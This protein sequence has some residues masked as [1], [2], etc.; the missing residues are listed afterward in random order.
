MS[1]RD[2]VYEELERYGI[3]PSRISRLVIKEGSRLLVYLK[4]ERKPVK[5][6][7][8]YLVRLAKLSTLNLPLD[9]ELS[10][11]QLLKRLYGI[12]TV[13]GGMRIPFSKFV[14]QNEK[15]SSRELAEELENLEKKYSVS[16]QCRIYREGLEVAILK[17]LTEMFG[18][19]FKAYE[20]MLKE[21]HPTTENLLNALTELYKI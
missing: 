4:D 20:E 3:S 11:E 7:D 1:V 21:A 18:G 12:K 9:F 17:R 19:S 8:P 14:A 16:E 15:V 13:F 2:A 10:R 6:E 5:I